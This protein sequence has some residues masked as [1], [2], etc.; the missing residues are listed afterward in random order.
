MRS[1]NLARDVR[2]PEPSAPGLDSFVR[3]AR[4]SPSPGV[5]TWGRSRLVVTITDRDRCSAPGTNGPWHRRPVKSAPGQA[6][7]HSVGPSTD[8]RH[9][10]GLDHSGDTRTVGGCA[11][12]RG[13]RSVEGSDAPADPGT[14]LPSAPR[15]VRE[16]PG[17]PM[18]L[19][20]WLR[21]QPRCL[22]ENDHR[23]TDPA[24]AAVANKTARGA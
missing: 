16:L 3:W 23:D 5:S 10:D 13:H 17:R 18:G 19:N 22:E 6:D 15:A 14:Q 12:L 8:S 7:V 2:I 24:L 11:G 9:A 21:S 20:A 1:A 4:R